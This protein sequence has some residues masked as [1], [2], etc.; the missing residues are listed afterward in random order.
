MKR[1]AWVV[2]VEMGYGHQRAASPLSEIA[3]ERIITANSDKW[4]SQKDRR[5]WN[6][7]K[8]FPPSI[9]SLTCHGQHTRYSISSNSAGV[10]SARAYCTI[11]KR[12]KYLLLRH[13]LPRQWPQNIMAYGMDT[14]SSPIRTSIA[15]GLQTILKKARSNILLL[16][17]M[18]FSD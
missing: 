11:S 8:L 2:S 18:S 9:P 7:A 15:F 10:D 5:V 3:C 16:A 17:S 1:K 4:V 6:H 12:K 13:I 14:A